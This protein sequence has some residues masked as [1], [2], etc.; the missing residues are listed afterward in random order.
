MPIDA[1]SAHLGFHAHPSQEFHQR[2]VHGNPRA[3]DIRFGVVVQANTR[4]DDASAVPRRI[5]GTVDVLCHDG[6]KEINV[7][8]L[9]GPVNPKNGDGEHDTPYT[10]SQCVLITTAGGTCY[11]SGFVRP[12]TVGF[13]SNDG[14]A[15]LHPPAL[16][17]TRGSWVRTAAGGRAEMRLTS[18][19]LLVLASSP[20]C[21]MVFNPGTNE[22]TLVTQ[23]MSRS[24]DGYTARVGRLVGNQV[25]PDPRTVS[26]ET[27]MTGAAAATATHVVEENGAVTGTTVRRVSVLLGGKLLQG[28]ETVDATGNFVG[29]WRSYRFGSSGAQENIVLGQ[30]LK[31]FLKDF[32]ELFAKHTHQSA[33]GPTTPP[34][35]ALEATKLAAHPV[36]DEAIL[37]SFMF[38]QKIGPI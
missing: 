36:S 18:A 28:R 9:G 6:T 37:S 15:Q 35:E 16:S 30:V 26:K 5:P 8:V 4:E 38:A 2:W 34:V 13:A 19:G 17:D 33:V 29:A 3:R 7:Q 1:E 27:F 24:A 12:Q 11:A 21:R 32:L 14:E 20:A 23:T 25:S 22:W 10:G 31:Q